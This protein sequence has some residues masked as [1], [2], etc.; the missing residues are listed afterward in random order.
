[1]TR[2][3]IPQQ[4]QKAHIDMLLRQYESLEASYSEA[5]DKCARLTDELAAQRSIANGLLA[6]LNAISKEL[7]KAIEA[8]RQTITSR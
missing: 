5:C 1:M 6:E 7:S 8:E 4:D 3:S 2:K